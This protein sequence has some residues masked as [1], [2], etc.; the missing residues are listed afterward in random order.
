MPV[1]TRSGTRSF[2]RPEE[3]EDEDDGTHDGRGDRHRMECGLH[4][5]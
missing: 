2:P 4:Q 3:E 1:K 5:P